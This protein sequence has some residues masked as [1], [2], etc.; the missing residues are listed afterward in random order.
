[1][2]NSFLYI[3][4]FIT[5]SF[6][7]FGQSQQDEEPPYYKLGMLIDYEKDSEIPLIAKYDGFGL[8]L[9]SEASLEDF[10]PA[11]GY[12]YSFPT[13]PGWA[14]AYYTA[15]T[16]WA[17]LTNQS[18]QA[19]VTAY[20]YDPIF[21]NGQGM[22]DT[23]LCRSAVFLP[24]LLSEIVKSGSKRL[25]IDKSSCRGANGFEESQ[26]LLNLTS[27]SRLTDKNQSQEDNINA[28]KQS[29]ADFH[30]VVFG[31]EVAESFYL[32]DTDGYFQPTEEEKAMVGS[33]LGHALTIVGYDDNQFGGAFRVVNSWGNNW[34]DNGYCWISYED[35]IDF[36]TAAFSFKSELKRPELVASG[37]D[38]DGFGRKKISK[39]GFFEGYLDS[40]GKP[41]K[42][43][44]INEKLKKGKGGKRYMK[45]LV[46]KN[47]GFLIYSEDNDAIP[48]AAVIY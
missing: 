16:E 35:F 17:L 15:T 31:M 33:L 7:S 11:V 23:A 8:D 43:I 10:V 42:G 24:D 27:V 9:P 6:V 12:Q 32:V 21:M 38:S 1:M 5:G 39:Y 29:L 13:S 3:L 41:D 44:Y 34:G 19:I 20:A 40:K 37:A 4:S 26:S 22:Q 36:H 46:N 48:I 30:P 47:G 14:V 25:N 18:N 2:R 28:I 45:K